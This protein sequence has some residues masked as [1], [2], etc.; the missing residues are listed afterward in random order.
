MRIKI[1]IQ[2]FYDI[3]ENT[4]QLLAYPTAGGIIL[5][6][7][8]CFVFKNNDKP[9]TYI[10]SEFWA[11]LGIWIGFWMTLIPAVFLSGL[12]YEMGRQLIPLACITTIF[13]AKSIEY[14]IKSRYSKNNHAN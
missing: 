1:N 5:A 7:L 6:L 12:Y 9:L 3:Y 8:S 13:I 10:R 2:E 4:L 14:F 11:S